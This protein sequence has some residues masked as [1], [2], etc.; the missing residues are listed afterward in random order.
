LVNEMN[1]TLARRRRGWLPRRRPAPGLAAAATDDDSA[2][3]DPPW[4]TVYALSGSSQV[5]GFD[6]LRVVSKAGQNL[7][8]N[9]DTGAV[10]GN[11]A[12]GSLTYTT[13]PPAD[14][15]AGKQ[16][17]A[18]GAAYT[19]NFAGTTATTLYDLDAGLD[20]LALQNPPNNG[21]LRTVGALQQD[22]GD[23]LGF[24]AVSVAGGSRLADLL[25]RRYAGGAPEA[26]LAVFRPA[27][28]RQARL[29]SVDLA[30]GRLRDRG[31][32][33]GGGGVQGL[34]IALDAP[35]GGGEAD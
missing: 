15:N 19:N 9:P 27:G 7:R 31:T 25:S 11:T 4:R 10:V 5:L 28:S 29:Y 18:V 22:A 16:P 8:I 12:G 23:L 34:A 2:D 3:A 35:G 21:T 6:P 33:A 13:Q 30:S 1:R 17:G 20:V 26:G 24:D 14:P 32:L